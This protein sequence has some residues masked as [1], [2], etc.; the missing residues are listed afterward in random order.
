MSRSVNNPILALVGIVVVV[1][2]LGAKGIASYA[3]VDYV[4]ATVTSKERIT[5]NEDSY[6]LVFTDKETFINKDSI[7][8]LKYG[9]SD[10]YGNIQEGETYEFK[11]TLF[12][13]PFFSW[14]RNIITIE[15]PDGLPALN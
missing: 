4:T 2:L 5:S 8:F 1:L 6:Y 10:L 9:S 13:V 7:W 14:Y 11:V 12:R 3:T 15:E